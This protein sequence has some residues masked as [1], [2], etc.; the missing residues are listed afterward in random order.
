MLSGDRAGRHAIEI[1]PL[2]TGDQ[3]L[4]ITR[5]AGIDAQRVGY[6]PRRDRVTELRG[7]VVVDPDLEWPAIRR[8]DRKAGWEALGQYA[9]QV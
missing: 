2:G 3:R 4:Q 8:V 5:A 1:D 9:D 7:D 6:N